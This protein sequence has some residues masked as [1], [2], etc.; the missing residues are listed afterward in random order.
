MCIFFPL[1]PLKC[2]R[3]EYTR[4]VAASNLI[5]VGPNPEQRCTLLA[6]QLGKLLGHAAGVNMLLRGCSTIEEKI[7]R[8]EQEILR[9]QVTLLNSNVRPRPPPGHVSSAAAPTVLNPPV[10]CECMTQNLDD[11]MSPITYSQCEQDA[12]AFLNVSSLRVACRLNHQLDPSPM[13]IR[14]FRSAANPP[15]MRRQ[16]LACSG[17]VDKVSI[18]LGGERVGVPKQM[19]AR[20]DSAE[21]SG[22]SEPNPASGSSEQDP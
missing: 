22:S 4:H 16:N 5:A 17:F 7:A 9:A 15:P 2:C 20:P 12:V 13:T 1:A 6:Q 8:L 11:W 18:G 10:R 19:A 3:G 14:H 21:G